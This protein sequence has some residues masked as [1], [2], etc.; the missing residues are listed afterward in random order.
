MFLA[1]SVF[2]AAVVLLGHLHYS[3]DVL[4]AVFVAYAVYHFVDRYFPKE[5][6]LFLSEQKYL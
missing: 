5:H 3:I 6:A 1:W 4:G 2:F